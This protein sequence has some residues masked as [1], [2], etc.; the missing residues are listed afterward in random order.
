MDSTQIRKALERLV[1]PS[2]C[3]FVGVFPRDLIPN[4]FTKYPACFVCNNDCSDSNGTHWLA[5]YYANPN[6]C[7]FYDSFAFNPTFYGFDIAPTIQNTHSLQSLHSSVCGQFCIHF[8]YH[9][10]LGHSLNSIVSAFSSHDK[11]WNDYQVAHFVK[12]MFKISNPALSKSQCPCIQ[13]SKSKS[14]MICC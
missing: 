2:T 12:K 14:R 3:D 7:E 1:N 10:S 11:I 8:L 13:K 6:Y 9:R 5:I 4:N